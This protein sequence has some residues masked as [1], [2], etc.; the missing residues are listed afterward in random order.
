MRYILVHGAWHGGWSW[1]KV[2]PFLEQAGHTVLAPDLPGH[3]QDQ[4]ELGFVTLDAYVHHVLSLVERSPEPVILVGHD[5]GG[6]VIS[7]VAEDQPE[8]VRALVYVSAFLPRTGESALQLW[9][10]DQFSRIEQ[11]INVDNV[12]GVAQIYASQAASVLY[13]DC[14]YADVLVAQEH[15]TPQALAPLLTPVWLSERFASV[16][17]AALMCRYDQAIGLNLQTVM[18]TQTPCQIGLAPLKSGHAPFFSVPD[19]LAARLLEVAHAVRTKRPQHGTESER[20]A[21]G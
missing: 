7:Q 11:C 2:I 13:H 16:P 5:L 20:H 3:G 21:H 8:H 12:A 9:A 1:R 19:Q 6:V 15:L 18:Y 17:R 4:T 14:S 10:T